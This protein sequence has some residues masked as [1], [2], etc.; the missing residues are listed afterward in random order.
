MSENFWDK[1]Q[2][3][4]YFKYLN[5]KSCNMSENSSEDWNESIKEESLEKK[6]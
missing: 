1:V 5:K 3:K 4:A 2:K 6:N